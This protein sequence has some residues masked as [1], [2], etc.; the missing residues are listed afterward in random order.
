[1]KICF[2]DHI[3][4]NLK[5][6]V[7]EGCLIDIHGPLQD[8]ARLVE[9][10]Q[11]ADILCTRDQFMKYDR[12]VIDQ[13]PKLRLIVTRSTGYNHIDW[14]HAASKGIPVCN[15]PGYGSNTVAEFAAGL[16]LSVS[17]K[18]PKAAQRY[19][20]NDYSI[21]GLEGVDL[22]GKTIGIVGTGSIG[23]KM[24]RI[25]K[26][27]SMHVC[28][29]DAIEDKMSAERI[30][31]AYVTFEELLQKSDVVSL[32]LPLNEKTHHIINAQTLSRMKTGAILINTG[33][34]ELVD[35]EALIVALKERRLFGVGLD[36]IEGERERIYDFGDLN[37]VVSTHIG[38]FTHEAVSR[39]VTIALNNIRAF[40][41]GVPTNVVN[42]DFLE[43]K[44]A[45]DETP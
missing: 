35:T 33:R 38:W 3:F 19:S 34:G 41:K 6:I 42:Q 43:Q 27:L 21:D 12:S 7:I 2:V 45:N 5:D 30:G 32:H 16:M 14:K 39:I 18:I 44:G 24:A 13:L 37:A 31:F 15:V 36:V 29:Y 9:L 10:A 4:E 23:L 25:V 28:A 11:D 26:G 22:E 1:M 40:L 8:P 20:Q 17:R